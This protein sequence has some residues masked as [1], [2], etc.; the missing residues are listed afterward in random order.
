M[1][2]PLGGTSV[3]SAIMATW[4]PLKWTCQH[5]GRAF[6]LCPVVTSCKGTPFWEACLKSILSP[7]RARGRVVV[8]VLV[9]RKSRRGQSQ[10]G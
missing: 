5:L 6:E 3:W 7:N 2:S 8:T 4:T 1:A 10:Q 9:K